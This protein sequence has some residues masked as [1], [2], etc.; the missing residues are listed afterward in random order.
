MTNTNVLADG[1]T[2][3]SGSGAAPTLFTLLEG[4]N[5][6]TNT[7]VN[8]QGTGTVATRDVDIFTV[9]I[10]AGFILSEINITNFVSTDNVGFA[11]FLE[12]N[13][14]PVDFASSGFD[15]SILLGLALFGDDTDLLAD[16]SAGIGNNNFIGF[17]PSAGLAGDTSYTFLVQQNGNNV[18]DYTFDFV[19]ERTAFILTEGS[20]TFTGTD[21]DDVICLLYTSPSPRDKRQ[22]RMP[23]SA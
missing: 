15:S 13:S 18:I 7:V 9:T 21:D 17:D 8:A 12:G 10:P 20:D 5:T 19:L 4:S 6:I 16:L 2:D 11:A 14:F 3:L 22:S 23:S 1:T